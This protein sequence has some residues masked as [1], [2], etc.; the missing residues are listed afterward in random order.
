MPIGGGVGKVFHLGKLPMNLKLESYYNVVHPDN[1]SNWQLR[2][3]V[4]F[5]LPK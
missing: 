4:V 5:I 1:G 2:L 3:Q